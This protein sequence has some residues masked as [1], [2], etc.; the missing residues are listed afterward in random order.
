MTY[1]LLS[2]P[3]QATPLIYVGPE[4]SPNGSLASPMGT[5]VITVARQI[6]LKKA[7]DTGFY[8]WTELPLDKLLQPDPGGP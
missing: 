8:G 7:G 5:L 3:D 2:N 6:Y 4:G 1:T